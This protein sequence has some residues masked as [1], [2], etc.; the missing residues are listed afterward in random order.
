M[1][2]AAS[3]SSNLP[4]AYACHSWLRKLFKLPD[5]SSN[6]WRLKSFDFLEFA[7]L[8]RGAATVN[9]KFFR[10]LLSCFLCFL[11]LRNAHCQFRLTNSPL[12]R[13]NSPLETR[14]LSLIP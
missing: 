3:W 1:F 11:R 6:F 13:R 8:C 2:K 14:N 10:G 4:Y 5:L 7:T 12:K 9:R